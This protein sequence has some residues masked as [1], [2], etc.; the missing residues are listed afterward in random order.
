MS[1]PSILFVEEYSS[2]NINETTGADID[3]LQMSSESD[4][5]AGNIMENPLPVPE[6]SGVEIIIDN[7]DQHEPM[8]HHEVKSDT[9]SKCDKAVQTLTKKEDSMLSDKYEHNDKAIH[10]YT[11]LE[12]YQKLIYVF[13]TL[14][15]C[16][17]SK[18]FYDMPPTMTAFEQF[19][20]TLMILRRHKEFEEI[21]MMY[22]I[23]VKQVSNIFITWI[24]LMALQ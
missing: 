24:R 23:S 22:F 17:N 9:V 14:G 3:P 21:A 1:D 2:L 4:E 5:Y 11:G 19:L 18:Y 10:F 13:Y 15:D 16:S 7:A 6:E 20:I 12:T 8:A